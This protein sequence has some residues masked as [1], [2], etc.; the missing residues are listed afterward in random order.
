MK[1]DAV[2]LIAEDDDGH[3]ELI[4]KNLLRSGLQNEM[5]R[6][7]NGRKILDFLHE[8]DKTV[9]PEQ[10]VQEYVLLLDLRIPETDGMEVLEKIK[11]SRKLRKIPVIILTVIDDANTIEQCHNLGCSIYIVKPTEYEEFADT[12]QKIGHFLSAVE[13]APIE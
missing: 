4:R 2:I 13:L 8:L 12:V 7:T 9:E 10:S 1:K 11:Q 6:F 5:Q 3:F